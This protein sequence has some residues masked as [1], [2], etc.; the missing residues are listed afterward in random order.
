MTTVGPKP[1]DAGTNDSSSERLRFRVVGMDCSND[2]E[3]IEETASKVL[4][5]E[6]VKVSIATQVLTTR[7]RVLTASNWATEW[8]QE[9]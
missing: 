1:R 3:E 9:L 6:E 5:V 4:G 7:V 2:A 8:L